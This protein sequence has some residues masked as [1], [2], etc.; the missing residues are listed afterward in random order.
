MWAG[1]A[2][3]T[4]IKRKRKR[5]RRKK[6]KVLPN[7][8]LKNIALSIS[9]PRNFIIAR[10]KS[11][12]KWQFVH[13]TSLIWWLRISCKPISGDAGQH[14]QMLRTIVS[15]SITVIIGS[16]KTRYKLIK[17]SVLTVRRQKKTNINKAFILKIH[18]TRLEWWKRRRMLGMPSVKLSRLIHPTQ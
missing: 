7:Q 17:V 2:N 3:L 11:R 1:S 4:P 14:A 16:E 10:R 5:K 9:F 13:L 8:K 6:L 15:A 18:Q 12:S